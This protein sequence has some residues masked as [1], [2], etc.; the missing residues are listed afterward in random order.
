M[1]NE[2]SVRAKTRRVF[3]H[4]EPPWERKISCDSHWLGVPTTHRTEFRFPG[5]SRAGQWGKTVL[6]CS[7]LTGGIAN[8]MKRFWSVGF[9]CMYGA[10]TWPCLRR[11]PVNAAS[12][13]HLPF[14]R[15]T[16]K[17]TPLRRYSS[18][19]P[20][21]RECPVSGGLPAS[22]RAFRIRVRK[23]LFDIGREAPRW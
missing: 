3:R 12:L 11:Y 1:T 23:T 5:A 4:K 15:T 22:L 16:E 2:K 7:Y 6:T 8:R 10:R 13:A 19:P 9:S 20:T 17:S 18:V 14:T 21:L